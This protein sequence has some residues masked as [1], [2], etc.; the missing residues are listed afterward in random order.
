MYKKPKLDQPKIERQSSNNPT[1]SSNISDPESVK[2]STYMVAGSGLSMLSDK[3]PIAMRSRETDPT[4]V[5]TRGDYS[6]SCSDFESLS[7]QKP[8]KLVRFTA[9][10]D[11]TKSKPQEPECIVLSDYDVLPE[12]SLSNGYFQIQVNLKN[13]FFFTLFLFK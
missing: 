10:S 1:A 5:L 7:G 13:L 11:F 2:S 9:Q 6:S 4:D 8:A 3:R 12:D